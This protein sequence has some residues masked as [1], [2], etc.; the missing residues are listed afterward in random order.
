MTVGA[1]V[2]GIRR[3]SSSLCS[4][5]QTFPGHWPLCTTTSLPDRPSISFI[6]SEDSQEEETFVPYARTLP[7]VNSVLNVENVQSLTVNCHAVNPEHFMPCSSKS[8]A[9]RPTV[10]LKNSMKDFSCVDQLPF[11]QP[12]TNAYTLTLNRPSGARLHQF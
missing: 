2:E 11:A 3:M 6:Y 9:L 5:Y 1:T 4:L 12:A 7:C 10:N 8:K